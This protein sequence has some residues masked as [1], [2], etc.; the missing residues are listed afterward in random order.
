MD[1][2]TSDLRPPRNHLPLVAVGA[3]LLLVSTSAWAANAYVRMNQ[4]GYELGAP[5]RWQISSVRG[6]VS[7]RDSGR[8]FG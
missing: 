5:T 8:H 7:H 4:L 3:L 6:M 1:P 2:Q